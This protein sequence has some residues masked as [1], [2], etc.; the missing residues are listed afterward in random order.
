[1][2]LAFHPALREIEGRLARPA[3][4]GCKSACGPIRRSATWATK[5]ATKARRPARRLHQ[6]GFRHAAASCGSIAPS[7]RASRPRSNSAL[8]QTR[9]QVITTVRHGLL[10]SAGAER[11][12]TLAHQL[13]DIAGEAVRVSDQRLQALDI[14]RSALLQSQIESESAILLEQQAEQRQA[15]PAAVWPRAIGNQNAEPTLLEDVLVRPLPEIDWAAARSRLLAESPELAELHFEI[16]RAKW[17]RRARN[18]R[19]R[20]QCQ[21]ASRSRLRRCD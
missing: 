16:E 5:S 19:P 17:D 11:A 1:M 13:S 3:A 20:A 21:R 4:N 9:L 10:R 15:P 12:V 8:Q 6:P 18:G 7:S 2:A 14:P